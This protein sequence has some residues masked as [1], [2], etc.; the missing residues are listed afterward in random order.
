MVD[1]NGSPLAR[2]IRVLERRGAPKRHTLDPTCPAAARAGLSADAPADLTPASPSLP[3][4]QSSLRGRS[5]SRSGASCAAP[6][7]FR[8]PVGRYAVPRV[9]HMIC[10]GGKRDL[11]LDLKTARCP[12][13]ARPAP[14]VPR[15]SG[16]RAFP[17]SV[18]PRQSVTQ[19]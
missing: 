16:P 7:G 14:W 15:W 5:I 13:A 2:V 3:D 11:V 6:V 19:T 9:D 10:D 12:D 1:R 4:L 17:R 18:G 8:V